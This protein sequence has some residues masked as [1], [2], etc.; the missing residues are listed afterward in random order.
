MNGENDCFTFELLGCD[1]AGGNRICN[2]SASVS[3]S[4]LR[5]AAIDKSDVSGRVK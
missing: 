5:G 2:D 1:G 3:V 4:S